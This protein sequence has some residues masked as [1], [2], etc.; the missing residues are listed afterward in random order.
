METVAGMSQPDFAGLYRAYLDCRRRKRRTPSAQRYE[1]R[2][3]DNLF[4]TLA[5]LR[6]RSYSPSPA[7]RFVA[8]GPK[9]REIHAADFADRVVHHWLVPRLERLFEPVF[10]HDVYSNRPGK[11]THRAVRR[12]QGFIHGVRAGGGEAWYL[13]LDIA[14]FFNS[15]DRAIL[16]RLLQQR[17]RKALRQGKIDC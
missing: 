2:L 15:I 11:G 7:I 8:Q 3:L 5:A 16:F 17:L 14:N 6:E 12:L 4:Q 9:S 13:Q 10:I 1:M